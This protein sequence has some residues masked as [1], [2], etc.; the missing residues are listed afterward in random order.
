MKISLLNILV[1]KQKSKENLEYLILNK[2]VVYLKISQRDFR[3]EKQKLI[4]ICL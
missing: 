3:K 4:C 1:K 2:Y